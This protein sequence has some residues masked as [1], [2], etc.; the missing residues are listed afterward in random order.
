MKKKVLLVTVTVLCCLVFGELFL[1][2]FFRVSNGIWLWQIDTFIVDY[3]IPASGGSQYTLRPDF[4]D[5][6]R[7]ITINSMGYRGPAV[8]Q[9]DENRQ[10]IVNLGDSV[11]F[12][13]GVKDNETY[14]Y[15]LQ[16]QLERNTFTNTDVL[17][18]GVTSYNLR[19]SFFR[20]MSEVKEDY[21]PDIVTF[22]AVNDINLLFNLRDTW[23]PD[24]TW[25]DINQNSPGAIFAWHYYVSKVFSR[26]T[27]EIPGHDTQMN[28]DVML[29]YIKNELVP[30]IVSYCEMNNISIVFIPINPFYYSADTEVNDELSN[31]DLYRGFV[32]LCRDTIERYN[33]ILYEA[34]NKYSNVYYWDVCSLLDGY[35][36]EEM[37]ID[38]FHY[39]PKGN[40]VVGEGLFQFLKKNILE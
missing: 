37:Y 18:A 11:P 35:D 2:L 31:W 6:Q 38:L 3:I 29:E 27:T 39:S 30:E 14:S 19:Q 26:D 21:E 25:M 4:T 34:S 10:L 20:L 8:L 22:S 28:P 16:Q 7:G 17:N 9:R 15:I 5:T 40:Q 1:Q 13:V 33:E 23:T 36:R 24:V 32:T 12:G